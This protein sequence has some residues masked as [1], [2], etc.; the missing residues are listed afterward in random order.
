MRWIIQLETAT[1][2]NPRSPDFS[3]LD[4]VMMAPTTS[5]GKAIASKF[6]E[7]LTTKLKERAAIW[8]QERL[9]RE[10]R[11][12]LSKGSK[13]DTKGEGKG[14]GGTVRKDPKPKAKPVAGGGKGNN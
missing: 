12:H 10:E 6:T 13:G 4:I 3:G 2:R 8:K 5:E 7:H 14:K 11:R 9:Y 1:E